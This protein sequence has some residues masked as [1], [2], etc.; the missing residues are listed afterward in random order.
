MIKAVYVH[1]PFCASKCGYCSFN[2][3]SGMEEH[4]DAYTEALRADIK[5]SAVTV[6][7][8][9]IDSVYFGGGTPYYWGPERLTEMLELIGRTWDVNTAAEISFEANPGSL[10]TDG[11]A[12]LRQAGFNRI[13][14]GAQSFSDCC[15][16]TVGRRHCS[17]DIGRGVR[18]ARRAGFQNISLDLIYGLPRQSVDQWRKDLAQTVDLGPNH[19]SIYGLTLEPPTSLWRRVQEGHVSAAGDDLQAEMYEFGSEFLERRGYP[20][21]ELSSFA[22]DGYECRHNINYWRMGGY[23][24]VGAGA[25]S[26]IDSR[27]YWKEARPELYIKSFAT[28]G[29]GIEGAEELSPEQLAGDEAMLALRLREGLDV[30]YFSSRY[31]P[32]FLEDRS[33]SL[34][35][36]RGM[37]LVAPGRRLVLTPKGRLLA[38]EVMQAF[39]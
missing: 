19:I 32:G 33:G 16:S 2:S 15:L 35:E 23:L 18:S 4:F 12:M 28:D 20:L 36:L 25:H 11:L 37:N 3:Y 29:A 24:G 10:S 13:S 9:K 22:P 38:S 30:D 1:I 34:E 8:E 21:Y 26:F 17:A 39:V 31:G 6:A 7:A 27:R 14:I 5:R